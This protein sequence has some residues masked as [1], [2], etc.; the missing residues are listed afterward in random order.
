MVKLKRMKQIKDSQQGLG[1][2]ETLVAVAILG[3]ALVT[4]IS[5]L[6]TGAM[7]VGVNEQE[8]IAQRLAQSQIEY[9]QNLA[10]SPAGAYPVIAVPA[11]Y[12]LTVTTDSVPDGDVNIQKIIV[13]VLRD[14]ASIFEVSGYKV[15]R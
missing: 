1:L 13:T 2:V 3:T 11:G 4:F 5:A 12:S 6:S 14:G 9:T 7:S 8:T 15:N 10:F